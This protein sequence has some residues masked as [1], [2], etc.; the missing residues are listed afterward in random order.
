MADTTRI[1]ERL[2]AARQGLLAAVAG[3]PEE[4][5]RAQ[6][7]PEVWSP[8][9]IF[10]HLAQVESAISAGA[11]KMIQS[12]PRPLTL[13]ERIHLPSRLAEFRLVKRESPIPL[14]AQLLTGKQESLARLEA[15]R[16]ETLRVLALGD[17]RNLSAWHYRHPFF[18]YL[19]FYQWFR[20]I[21]YHEIRHTKQIREMG[22]R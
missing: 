6:P 20:T 8:A 11:A 5:W 15:V 3:I 7:A 13:R 14:D 12:P 10:V 4:K 19:N 9:H 16:A 1:T 2:A 18:G 17:E 21:G 22:A